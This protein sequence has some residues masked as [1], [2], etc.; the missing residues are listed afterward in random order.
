MNPSDRPDPAGPR[1]AAAKSQWSPRGRWAGMGSLAPSEWLF[2]VSLPLAVVAVIYS[3][4]LSFKE[5]QR[6]EGAKSNAMELAKWAEAAGAKHEK[7]EPT[8]PAGC[9]AIAAPAATAS[10]PAASGAPAEQAASGAEAHAADSAA[11]A[12]GAAPAAVSAAPAA[13]A[14]S[15]PPSTWAK[16]KQALASPGGPLAEAVN[17]FNPKESV[18][19][20]KCERDKPLTRGQ[21][22][23]EKGTSPPPGI[24]GSVTYAAIEDT[25]PMVKGLM[26]KI[27]VCDKGS[28]PIKVSEVKL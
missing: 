11:S 26:L 21:V 19:G 22:V 3:G 8:L 24:P 18:L 28:Y 9:S 20:V 7:G 25:E 13:P 5:G 23:V 2:L 17:T 6:L 16:C 1:P 4:T 15:A 12:A 27:I 14:A 10:T